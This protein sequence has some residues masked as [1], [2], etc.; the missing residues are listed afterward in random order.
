MRIAPVAHPYARH[1]E[2]PRVTESFLPD[3]NAVANS[4]GPAVEALA[5]RDGR[6][7][8]EHLVGTLPG[9]RWSVFGGGG[10]GGGGFLTVRRVGQFE[11]TDKSG[12][13]DRRWWHA[14]ECG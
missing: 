3:V 2:P 4:A 12:L 5:E 10:G 11:P 6:L 13:S 14:A 8:A 1:R 7:L 9:G